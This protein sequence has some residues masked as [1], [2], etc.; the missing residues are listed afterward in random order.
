MERLGAPTNLWATALSGSQI[1][2]R[3]KDNSNDE[4]GFSIE[5]SDGADFT[6]IATLSADDTIY[7]DD[8][9]PP[10][11]SYT[12][13]I[14][15]FKGEAYYLYSNVAWAMTLA[16]DGSPAYAYNPQPPDSAEDIPL[17]SILSWTAGAGSESHDI[18]FSISVPP[19]YQGNQTETNFNPG[20]LE[21]NTTYYWR[22]DEVNQA[23]TT[24]GVLWMFT[25]L[26][27]PLP[28]QLVAH[29]SLNEA[30]GLELEDATVNGNNGT[31]INMDEQSGV[32]GIEGRAL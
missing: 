16:S 31:L 22:I 6:E 10:L 20:D 26:R 14:R 24:E 15:N 18:Y 3:W 29:W 23:G 9:L 30:T 32:E 19:T 4:D 7:V 28:S 17:N 27:E 5:R 25:A 8:N 13:R 1:E 2:L 12:Y 21:E 11:T